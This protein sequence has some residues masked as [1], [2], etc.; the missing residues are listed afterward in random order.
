MG[1]KTYYMCF[2][3]DKET[4]N[5][6]VTYPSVISKIDYIVHCLKRLEQ[7]VSV[8]SIAPS[9][10]GKF[11][12]AVKKI[13]E[14]EEH[15]FLKSYTP[16]NRIFKKISFII[17]NLRIL[18]FLFKNVKKDDT[19]LV[20]HSLYNR[21]W[22]KAYNC[23]AKRNIILQ[24][25]DVFS[26]LSSETEKFEKIEWRILKSVDKCICVNDILK[27]DLRKTK[28]T[29]V[30]MGNYSLP[31]K[32]LKQKTDRIKLVY[33]GVIEQE[34]NAAFLAARAMEFLPSNYELNILGFGT[35][36]NIADLEKLISDINSRKT[37][38]CVFYLGKKSGDA[39]YEFLQSCDIALSTHAYDE[40]TMSSADYTF[41][42]K[43]LAY[44]GNN[45]RVVAQ[46][47]SV[48]EKSS[49]CEFISFYDKPEP[50]Q[51]AKCIQQIDLNKEYD[52]RE[53]IKE[54][55]QKFLVGLGN[56]VNK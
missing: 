41:P 21:F 4:E 47:L 37:E 51:I 34:R 27:N 19:V 3:S 16:E 30:S 33:A 8:V 39:Y 24:I 1:G 42:S 38:K 32:F 14:N 13:D 54:L 43:V 6:I 28:M 50:E 44:L 11:D 25:E 12:G 36:K 17:H 10:K 46:R 29:L 49:V 55:D 20:Y 40:K 2:Y 26:E 18:A 5:T 45:L 31:K 9:I 35:D 23:F 7:N 53:H 48:L 56:M 52:S 15:I 22:F